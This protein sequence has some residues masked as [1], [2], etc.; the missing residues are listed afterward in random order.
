MH[1]GNGVDL[2]IEKMLWSI[3]S[4][5]LVAG[6][7]ITIVMFLQTYIFFKARSNQFDIDFD[8]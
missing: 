1:G 6:L 3:V 2:Q 8:N 7:P 5:W 4:V